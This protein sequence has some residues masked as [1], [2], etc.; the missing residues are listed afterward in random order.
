MQP[1]LGMGEF[2]GRDHGSRGLKSFSEI[3][4]KPIDAVNRSDVRRHVG[5]GF[6]F[7]MQSVW[8]CHELG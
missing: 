2:V 3:Y 8:N 4:F 1:L 7:N 6:W 5:L